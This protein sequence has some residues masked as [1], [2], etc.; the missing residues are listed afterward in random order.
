MMPSR[1]SVPTLLALGLAVKIATVLLR[2][3]EASAAARYF[4][5]DPGLKPVEI[6]HPIEG[7]VLPR[8]MS[9]PVLSWNTNTAGNGQWAAALKT[10]GGTWVF[11]NLQSGQFL[12]AADWERIRQSAGSNWV[13]LAI[14]SS[15]SNSPTRL[16]RGMVQFRFDPEPVATPLF[17]REV[18]LPF[19]E[20]VKDP[21]KI[22]WRFGS[23]DTGKPPPII[24]EHMP[25]CGNCHSFSRD[26]GTLA[27]DVDYANSKGSYIITRTGKE[28]TLATSDIITWD[29]F[30]R[31]EGKQTFGLLSQ[32]SPDGRYA[33]STVQDRSVFVPRPELAF[34]QLFFPLRGILASYD[35]DT[36][37]FAAL[38]GADDPAYV[39]SNP[40]WSPDG[41]TVVFA[42][43]R[44]G[45][46]KNARNQGAIL[47]S[48]E[49]CQEFLKDGKEFRFDLYRLP[50]NQGKGGKAEPIAGASRNG[51]SN[52]FPKYSPD[53]R[54]IVFCQASNYMLL[55]PDSELFIIP[56]AGGEARR[57][58]CNLS[59]MNSWHSW[60]PDGRWLVFSSKAHSDY[61]QL[62]LSRI[63]ERGEASPPVWLAHLVEPGRAANIPEFVNLPADAITK[64]REQFL[65]DYSFTRAGN[66]FFRAGDTD[67]AI[68][69][70]QQAVALNPKNA[71]AHQKLGFLLYFAK[72]Q[73]QEG[74]PHMQTAVNLEPNNP[75]AKFD[76]GMALSSRGDMSNALPHLARAVELL[77]NGFDR[78][79][80]ATDMHFH[81]A[82][83]YY[84]LGQPAACIKALEIVLKNAPT[85]GQAN[86]LMAMSQANLGGI[87]ESAA[88]YAK[89]VEA[90]PRLAQVPDYGDLLSRNLLDKGRLAEAA[91]EAE[92]AW[93]LA[94]AMG[95]TA[96]AAKLKE[97]YERCQQKP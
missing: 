68:A 47:L 24:L 97:R 14:V 28:M 66:E 15:D 16:A 6:Q 64:I 78:Q 67:N 32:I 92:K 45:D 46:L 49:E 20:A 81:L 72:K 42:R 51:R 87:E 80:N 85:H 70:Y 90:N 8:N 17:F 89:A 26:G 30:R 12:P 94:S 77:P 10:T 74:M 86:Y 96:Q 52:Y 54:W 62:Y 50:F 4:A 22:R 84:A 71:T 41:Q 76:L 25:V 31:E 7:A 91:A 40:T 1:F 43:N 37:Q 63:N 44:A 23:I 9:P 29:D 18:N 53:G 95:R 2:G 83:A 79:Y 57:L 11:T 21:S 3:D 38:P 55:Q 88:Y 35:R 13:Q 48:P 82:V 73:P 58:D 56:A 61:T 34:S 5:P 19:I 36:K 27:M 33:L 60:T 75:F 65:D 59:R 39:Q 69:K 93:K